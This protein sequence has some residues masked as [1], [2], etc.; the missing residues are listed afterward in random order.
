MRVLSL[1]G[2][3]IRSCL[4]STLLE[5]LSLE[6]DVYCGTS[7]GSFLALGLA[8]GIP[9]ADLTKIFTENGE[10]IFDSNW[11]REIEDLGGLSG[12]KYDNVRLIELLKKTFGNARMSDLKKAVIV[13]TFDMSTWSPVT[14]HSL[15]FSDRL[16]WEA[17]ICSAS[18][19]TFF[20]SYGSLI[21]GGVYA[22]SPSAVAVG[23][24][25]GAGVKLEHINLLSLGTGA[26]QM[27]IQAKD[28]DWGLSRW[29]PVI[30]NLLLDANESLADS[31]CHGL[32]GNNYHKLNPPLPDAIPLD[33]VDRIKDL[34]EIGQSADIDA[35]IQ[36]LNKYW[37]KVA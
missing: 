13:T 6:A 32:L 4:T 18:A 31:L 29:L 8:L 21:D 26:H 16:L 25:V 7:A 20:P 11:I 30:V 9:A 36:W 15:G 24:L 5:R 34:I 28:A 17:A 33:A 35:T 3:G 23:M 12:S 1:S 22:C 14:Y 10:S 2:G 19:P 37:S 27:G